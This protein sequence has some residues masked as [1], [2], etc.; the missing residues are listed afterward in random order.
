MLPK[1][2]FL[3]L[4]WIS[5]LVAVLS[6]C[7]G[8]GGGSGEA[9]TSIAF[10]S[11]PSIS[12]SLSDS[13]L[14]GGVSIGSVETSDAQGDRV[15]FSLEGADAVHF[16]I[17]DAGAVQ[18]R[19]PIDYEAR[20]DA[21]SNNT[22]EF[23]VIA[24]DANM[25]SEIT[26]VLSVQNA[27]E[28]RVVDAPVSNATI[29]IDLNNNR[30]AD[31]N[32]PMGST[33]DSGLFFIP[34]D[35]GI[36]NSGSVSFVALGGMDTLTGI[37]LQNL[38]LYAVDSQDA[39]STGLQIT[40]IST[41]LAETSEIG[42]QQSVIQSLGVDL[43]P[44][45]I[46]TRDLWSDAQ[47]GDSTA[48]NFQRANQQ[49]ALV[50][51]SVVSLTLTEETRGSI[52]VPGVVSAVA[53]E[54]AQAGVA[55]DG[56]DLGST[57]T[58]AL[59]MAAALENARAVNGLTP[60][61]IDNVN[62]VA[63]KVA[64]L[65]EL[66]SLDE[67]DPTSQTALVVVEASQTVLQEAIS[68]VAEGE[69]N[70]EAFMAATDNESFFGGA[71]SQLSKS[72][73]DEDGIPD[74]LDEDD[75]NDSMLDKSDP[76]PLD[77]T[78]TLDTDGDGI[79]NN[80]DSDDDGD[81]VLD[82]L[83]AFPLDATETIDTDSDGIG[84]NTDTDDDGDGV[85]DESDPFPLDAT[86]TLD[87]D[88]DG[89]GNNTD[90]DDD[91]DS[92]LDV[93]DAFPLDATEESDF[94]GDGVGNNADTDDDG[95][96]ILDLSDPEPYDAFPW[97]EEI[98]IAKRIDKNALPS[99]FFVVTET[100][101]LF[102]SYN[103]SSR[104]DLLQFDQSGNYTQRRNALRNRCYDFSDPNIK[105]GSW[106]WALNS[107]V[108]T[109]EAR[110]GRFNLYG[111]DP[112]KYPNVNWDL[113]DKKFNGMDPANVPY[114]FEV[115]S[116]ETRLRRDH[117]Y[118]LIDSDPALGTYSFYVRSIAST[119]LL[120][121]NPYVIDANEPISRSVASYHKLVTRA[122]SI[123]SDMSLT[124]AE[125]VV[126]SSST[127]AMPI[128]I[129][130]ATNNPGRESVTSCGERMSDDIAR[131]NSD[132]TG[133]AK[134]SQR[135]FLWEETYAENGQSYI[136][137]NFEDG[138]QIKL[139]KYADSEEY[140][141]VR[142]Q[143]FLQDGREFNA[144]NIAVRAEDELISPSTLQGKG[145]T[146]S[147]YW[148]PRDAL[149]REYSGAFTISL[150][151]EGTAL[152]HDGFSSNARSMSPSPFYWKNEVDE[153]S[154]QM[155][156]CTYGAP[157]T[158]DWQDTDFD[159]EIDTCR[160]PTPD[161][162][163][164]FPRTF[165]GLNFEV[166]ALTESGVWGFMEYHFEYIAQNETVTLDEFSSGVLRPRLL[167]Y[168][169]FWAF[170]ENLRDYDA[171]GVDNETDAY[172][173]ASIVGFDDLD[174]DGAPDTCNAEC[175]SSN[176]MADTDD[177]GD[178]V[179]DESDAFP[180]DATETSDFDG[181][182]IGNNADTD[183]DGDGVPDESDAFPLNELETLDTDGDGI[184]NNAD[185]DDDGDAVFD[186]LDAFP[187]DAMEIIDTDSDGI[188]NN[189][190]TDDDGDGVLDESDAF[191]L[192]ALETSD[193]DGDGVGNNADT[194][195]D[196]DGVEDTFDAE[197]FD[198]FPWDEEI[199]VAKEIDQSLF[200]RTFFVV[201]ETPDSVWQYNQGLAGQVL[202]FDKSGDYT[203]RRNALFNSCSSNRNT[204]T[205]VWGLNP[206]SILAVTRQDYNLFLQDSLYADHPNIKWDLVDEMTDYQSGRIQSSH[207]YWLIDS[208]PAL[209][210]YTFYVRETSSDF[211]PSDNPY[212]IDANKPI[213][214][215]EPYYFKVV[216]YG[217]S[218]KPDMSLTAAELVAGSSDTWAMPIGTY[219][220][221]E[222]ELSEDLATFNSDGTGAT[223]IAQ[224]SFTWAEAYAEN[225]QSYIEI[226]YEEGEQINIYKYAIG[227]EHI[228]VRAQAFL[229]D[230]S[231]LN[232]YGMAVSAKE[233]MLSASS[234]YGK[235]LSSSRFTNPSDAL[236]KKYVNTETLAFSSDGT[237]SRVAGGESESLVTYNWDIG[238]G[239][240]T[241]YMYSCF[242][243]DWPKKVS[244]WKDTNLDGLSDTCVGESSGPIYR[245]SGIRFEVLAMT[246]TGVWG[247]SK[248]T[249]ES[250]QNREIT[251]NDFK[252]G[253]LYE[254][255][256]L[257]F[258]AYTTFWA[259]DEN[260]SDYDADG[261]DNENDVY[262]F[263]SI[264]GFDDLDQ[265]GA[266]NTCDAECLSSGMMAD[267]D[268]D[269][270]GVE[271]DVDVDDDGDGSEDHSD[272]FPFDPTENL[273]TDLDGIGNNADPDDDGDG[274]TD[275]QEAMDGTDPLDA[276]SYVVAC[277]I[278][279]QT[280]SSSFSS[281]QLSKSQSSA[282][283]SINGVLSADSQVSLNL[284]NGSEYRV[285]LRAF[286]IYE[287]DGS[288]YTK[289]DDP[290]GLGGDG[291]LDVG[292]R[293]GLGA[294]IGSANLPVTAVYEYCHPENYSVERTCETL[295]GS[296]GPAEYSDLIDTDCDGYL[297]DS[298]PDDPGKW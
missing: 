97:D 285:Q 141:G 92:V 67:I 248:R 196:G 58:V 142:A 126:G 200:P 62:V 113:I 112:E 289:T 94:D 38:V 73:F 127:W 128:G 99:S 218:I 4:S 166:L 266:P 147:R 239:G 70:I 89:I 205:G 288:I 14:E 23:S 298:F 177:D 170:D 167:P 183:D 65:N 118:W 195:D 157:D 260:L 152:I 232:A 60:K 5:C 256:T 194:D 276:S 241:I 242:Y 172:P 297:V 190:D 226:N 64:Q 240:N 244:G 235:G 120:P 278:S 283:A 206:N 291:F 76:F 56:L 95:D 254:D 231:E 140:I 234:L 68:G 158:D 136:E 57:Q 270:D 149:S 47:S 79:G 82:T 273:D 222:G 169:S 91:G 90:T 134:I 11:P 27:F 35:E 165:I 18:F 189:T 271:N 108:S 42:Q 9:E 78:E 193:F 161:S 225:G 264:V 45:Q 54:L 211:L 164:L 281:G 208:D 245:F 268:V 246:E 171:D 84:N 107:I 49:V 29:A 46:L 210:T 156:S 124:A 16:T 143:M 63:E 2:R 279:S 257:K 191:P 259:F 103:W 280:A 202:Q 88:G 13:L 25:S 258:N 182:G 217:E 33:G 30:D 22:F 119:F 61:E 213:Y 214:T 104:G 282:L 146:G 293:V 295:L 3:Y 192:D 6:G 137:I 153:N 262:P 48:Q 12:S 237:V 247:F 230:G 261:V 187:L 212:V 101:D 77:A 238:E 174:Q 1:Y 236:S 287:R 249:E 154:I 114:V 85:L 81:G 53:Q 181:D 180:L 168:K 139:Y 160:G 163:N 123:E 50:M 80:T 39:A 265:D 122:E 106:S 19:S 197:P 272:A 31:V 198:A 275:S 52:A 184:G 252:S 250:L 220:I 224:R 162:L 243:Y 7:G 55:S 294:K 179:P 253:A 75:D 185:S 40:A 188:G 116:H 26:H 132:G 274:I 51:Q 21:D 173:F 20:L 43:D 201:T 223:K 251:V 269:G 221:C 215:S 100:P 135:N 229:A 102:W 121:D 131:F 186:E 125:L 290:E 15:S 69:T 93:F 96:G 292:E 28:G 111:V 233:N 8:G 66:L 144:Y 219:E 255:P 175:L 87:T 44:Q 296:Y 227:E 263:A 117:E 228:G 98:S 24:S 130:I 145:L 150:S 41:V 151:P 178:G 86:E 138:E 286:L 32:E 129:F 209:G 216:A 109:E 155:Y 105:S 199:S 72:D 203:R 74:V 148:N 71:A 115:H 17:S 277:E 59:V 37:E 207:E 159:G 133:T 204:V 176:M 10:N 110:N 36:A 267:T 284:Y 34:Y 83:D